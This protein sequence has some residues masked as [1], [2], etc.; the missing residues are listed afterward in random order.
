MQN[1]TT[2]VETGKNRND[3]G[4]DSLAGLMNMKRKKSLAQIVIKERR[5]MPL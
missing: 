1:V 5:G 3:D 4:P 2:F